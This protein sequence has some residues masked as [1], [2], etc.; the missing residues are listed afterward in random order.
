MKARKPPSALSV[1][2][3]EMLNAIRTGQVD[4]LV[5]QEADSQKLYALRSFAE[6]DQTRLK[7]R[8]AG[9]ERRRTN[10]QLQSLLD[11]RERLFQD[12]HDGCIQSIYAVG[13]TLEAAMALKAKP[14]EV[15]GMLGESIASLNLV[16]QELRSFMTGQDPQL[17]EGQNL[18][19]A[20]ERAVQT[21]GKRGVAFTVDIDSSA[22][23]ALPGKQTQQLIQIAR[24]CISNAVRHSGARTARISLRRRN[25][26]WHFE[27]SDDGKGFVA[28]QANKQGFGL[29]HILA[30]TRRIGG[31]AQ[32]IS[33][34]G[35]GTRVVVRIGNEAP[36]KVRPS[37]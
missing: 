14:R 9:K 27:V 16:I 29:H 34:P 19:T 21:A 22:M 13:L 4:A 6:I 1:E 32:V 5:I 37:A 26:I 30:R 10:A 25:G 24:E 12:L 7:L 23:H 28:G 20:I 2:A 8:L 18:R 11:E 31:K 36:R 3:E 35:K 17:G 33:T 15:E